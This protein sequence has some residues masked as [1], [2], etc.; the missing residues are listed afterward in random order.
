MIRMIRIVWNAGRWSPHLS[1]Q[2][3]MR[4]KE[5]RYGD[6]QFVYDREK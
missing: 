5:K 2:H 6:H 1:P 4:E 3:S